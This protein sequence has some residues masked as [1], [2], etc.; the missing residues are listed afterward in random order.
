MIS[1]VFF[2]ER[3]LDPRRLNTLLHYSMTPSHHQIPAIYKSSIVI[4]IPIPGNY[5]SLCISYRPISLIFP[6]AKVVEAL[7]FDSVNI[8]LL[9]AAD[10]HGFRPGHS[11]SSALLQLTSDIATGF[12]QRKPPHRA[13]CVAVDLTAAF[14]TVNH[15]VLLSKIERA[16][17]PET[18]SRWLSNYIRGRQ[19]VTSCRGVKSIARMS[20]LAFRKARSCHLRYS[21]SSDRPRPTEPV[22]RICDADD[23]I[24]WPSG[25]KIPELDHKVNTYLTDMSR[26]LRVN[27]LLISAPKS[28]VTLFTDLAQANTHSKINID[29]SELPLVRS[30]K[31]LGVYLGYLLFI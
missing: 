21:V 30:P 6:A 17:L 18:T 14:D 9:P 4:P 31:L 1:S 13:I 20:T 5:S 19:S 25:G 28:S 16:T 2:T 10:Q 22:M 29:D 27:S 7:M 8:H 26:F 23:I 15:N 24:V 12:N 3:T 11:T